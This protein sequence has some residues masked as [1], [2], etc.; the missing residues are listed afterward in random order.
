MQTIDNHY[1]YKRNGTYYY[2][3]RIP[4]DLQYKYSTKRIVVSLR[5]KSNRSAVMSAANISSQ[6]EG[7][8]SSIRV[9]KM[10]SRF[11]QEYAGESKGV[12]GTTLVD[13][14]NLYIKLKGV[15]K[16]KAF[17]QVAHRNVEYVVDCIGN[18]DLTRYTSSDASLFRDYLF[19]KGLVTTSVK[20]I[21]STIKA[22]V[23]LATTEL[24]LG[25]ANPF[26]NVFIP[27]KL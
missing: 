10:T 24:G 3:R 26:L 5:T 14:M 1:T 17:H 2:S 6:L 16:S 23:T 4:L 11:I 12:F 25:I 8:W 9:R 13:A 18:K 15:D 22:I 21:L 19:K 27:F 20:R 7:Y